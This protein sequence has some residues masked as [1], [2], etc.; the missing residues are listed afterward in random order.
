MNKTKEEL[1]EKKSSIFLSATSIIG[2]KVQNNVGEHLGD[3]KEIMLNVTTGKIQY[4]VIEFGGFLGLG[5]KYFAIPYK[6]LK[7]DPE[8]RVFILNQKKET[9]EK[10]PGF[11]KDHWPDTNVHSDMIDF[12]WGDFMGVNVGREY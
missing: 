7:L 4:F 1:E 5:E 3:I 10:A 8:N 11:D 6:L 2:D 12:Y 9:L